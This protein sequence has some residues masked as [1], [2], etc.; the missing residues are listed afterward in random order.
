V[1]SPDNGRGGGTATA[2]KPARHLRRPPLATDPA[3]GLRQDPYRSPLRDERLA[4]WLG[5][6]LGV[7]FSV[8]FI[9]GIYSHLQQHPVSWFPIPAAPAGLYRVTQG[10]HIAA[11]IASMP[12][13]A[14]KLWVIWPRFLSFPPFRRVSDIVERL[15]LLALVGGGIFMVFTGIADVAEWYPWRFSFTASHYWVAWITIGAIVAHVGAKWAITRQALRRPGNR[16]ALSEADPAIG[17]GN[18]G[19]HD[20]LTR[21]G[22]LGAV[23]A[24]SATLTAVTVGQTW[25]ALRRIAVLAPRQPGD[26]PVNRSA[27]NAGVI[28]SATSPTY[29]LTVT[30]KVAH[31][32]T[33]TLAELLALPAH[34][35]ELP[36]ACVEG[37]SWSGR[38]SGVRL[39][40]LLSMAGAA[41]DAAVRVE[42][43]ERHSIYRTAFVDHFQAHATNT[44]LATHLEGMPLPLD[45]GYP[46]RLIGPDRAGVVQTKWVT[47]VEVI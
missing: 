30:G 32:L 34:E 47:S 25:P 29:R 6:S 45:H 14:A 17:T 19:V 3:L 13:L 7:L 36:I 33:F 4:A 44:L 31:P 10:I 39:R 42:S 27:A 20:G 12:V 18:E 43:L 15:G 2:P 37:W 1:A 9:T 11:G 41:P 24:A 46:V 40:D 5:S 26:R 21:R 16:P 35:V 28:R 8:C 23:A 38:W 22:F